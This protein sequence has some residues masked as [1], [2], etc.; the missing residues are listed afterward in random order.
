MVVRVK[1]REE[2]LEIR[3]EALKEKVG[4]GEEGGDIR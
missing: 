3:R 4:K 2:D 1:G